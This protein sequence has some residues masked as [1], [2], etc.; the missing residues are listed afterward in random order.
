MTAVSRE[1]FSKNDLDRIGGIKNYM[2]PIYEDIFSTRKDIY[3]VCD[4]GCGNGFFSK[5]LLHNN[6]IELH[7]LDASHYGLEQAKIL[8][9][10]KT[11]KVNDFSVDKL[12]YENN[13]FD[14]VICKDVLEHLFDPLHLLSELKRITKDTGLIFLLVPNHFTIFH[15]LKFVFSINIDTQNYF[16]DAKEWNYP[17]IRFFS[18]KGMK[19]FLKEIDLVTEKN[20]CH[21]FSYFPFLRRFPGGSLIKRWLSRQWPS[22]FST[23]LAMTVK[24]GK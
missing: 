23:A 18:Q 9:Y 2:E 14:L 19:L 13:E 5:S 24:K 16:P 10:K 15:R 6:G 22:A 8:G 12:P 21:H 11:I 20:Y 3:K 1:W 17:H 7:G 4:V